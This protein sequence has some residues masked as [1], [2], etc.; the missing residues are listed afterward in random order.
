MRPFPWR[1]HWVRLGLLLVLIALP[2]VPVLWAKA[3]ADAHGCQLHE[4]FPNPCVIDGVD[5]GEMLY[6]LFLSGWLGVVTGAAGIFGL[7]AWAIALYGEM[8]RWGRG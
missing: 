4:G 2:F 7:I 1:K 6:G 5:Q 8:S 3:L